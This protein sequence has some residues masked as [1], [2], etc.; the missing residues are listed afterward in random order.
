MTKS[1]NT[2]VEFSISQRGANG[3]KDDDN[4][5]LFAIPLCDTA[6][7]VSDALRM[8]ARDSGIPDP[9][10]ITTTNL[11]KHVA[12]MSQVIAL[13][14]SELDILAQFMGHDIRV[15]RQ[16]YRLPE[17]TLHT[18]K[19]AKILLLMEKGNLSSKSGKMLD[20]IQVDLEGNFYII[21]TIMSRSSRKFT[22]YT[23][24]IT[25]C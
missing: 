5:Y 3:V 18:A 1:M 11:R 21:F 14:D 25:A 8:L 15:H 19:V 6:Y 24:N 22:K 4:P 9:E 17:D 23:I 2:N 13:G 7:R 12:V 10:H 16:Y 20:D